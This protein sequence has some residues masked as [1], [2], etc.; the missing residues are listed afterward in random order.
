MTTY[1]I[2]RIQSLIPVLLIVSVIVFSII[3]LTP[4]DPASV[5]LGDQASQE[6]IDAVREQ[7]GLNQPIHQ[8]YI[9]WLFNLFKGD[10]GY[11]YFMKQPVLDSIF[12][13]LGP[14]LSLAIIAEIFAIILAIPIG[15]LAAKRK[16]SLIDQ[17]FMGLSL[18]GISV[19]SFLLGLFLILIFSVQLQL[20]PVAGYAPLSSG[21]WNHI[22]HLILP[23]IALGTMHAA[24]IARMTRASLLDVLNLNFIKA[25]RA[26]GV[27]EGVLT[28]K[29][30]LR[31]SFIPIVTV[32]G[33]TLGALVAG[34]AV[35]ETIFNIPGIGQLILNSVERRDYS[36]IQGSILFI[37][38]SYLTINLFIDL[39]YGVID[40]R[41]KLGRK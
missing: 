33:Q 17:S 30:A 22:K 11:S 2:K 40:P 29:H 14:T 4:G 15:I 28:Y 38:L 35:T 39:L 12:S 41:V 24:L 27:K 34:A 6:E 31:N 37:T 21:F 36:V 20:F 16:G 1:I 13:H 19:P 23:A 10:F 3:H 18:L 8:Q 9:N 26:K 25:I 32:I 5:M 7:L